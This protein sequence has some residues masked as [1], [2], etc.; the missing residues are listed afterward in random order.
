MH[1]FL[2]LNSTYV[3]RMNRPK[4]HIILIEIQKGMHYLKKGQPKTIG[5]SYE[6]LV[7]FSVEQDFI[8]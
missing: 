8:F 3:K 2:L 4:S 6:N 7:W 5:K 1:C